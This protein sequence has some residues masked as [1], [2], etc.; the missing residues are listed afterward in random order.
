MDGVR[1]RVV[2]PKNQD[3]AA[4]TLPGMRQGRRPII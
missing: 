1:L 3:P 4:D 2:D